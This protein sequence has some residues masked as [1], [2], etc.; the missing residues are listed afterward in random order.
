MED[1]SVPNTNSEYVNAKTEYPKTLQTNNDMG[2]GFSKSFL[3]S[4]SGILRLLIIVNIN[5]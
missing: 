1:M 5:V 3:K 2:I 4:I